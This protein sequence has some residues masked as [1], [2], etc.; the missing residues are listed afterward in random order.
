MSDE[1]AGPSTAVASATFAQDDSIELIENLR[2]TTLGRHDLAEV[3]D[4]GEAAQ[5]LIDQAKIRPS[6]CRIG[7]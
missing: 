6:H 1:N 2:D 5:H 3:G 4:T 7:V